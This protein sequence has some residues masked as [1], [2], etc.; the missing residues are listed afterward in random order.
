M[1]VLLVDDHSSFR[2][3]LRALLKTNESVEV[4]GEAGS[5]YEAVEMAYKLS[6]DVVFMDIVLPGGYGGLEATRR[7]KESLPGVKVIMLSGHGENIYV[8]QALKTGA[9]GYVHK[10]CAFDELPIALETVGKGSP[11]LSP[12]LPYKFAEGEF[13]A[14]LINRAMGAYNSLTSREKEIIRLIADDLSREVIAKT[15][16]LKPKTVDRYRLNL[17]KKLKLK[18]KGEILQFARVVDLASNY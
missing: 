4:I 15:L 17:I 10:E 7:I 8:E 18:N 11:Y 9:L 6:P 13:E 16:G 3:S 1:R 12:S 5:G 2:Q 14:S